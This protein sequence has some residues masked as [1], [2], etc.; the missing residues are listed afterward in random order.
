MSHSSHSNIFFLKPDTPL[1]SV[2]VGDSCLLCCWSLSAERIS[3]WDPLTLSW[4]LPN[5][6]FI[7]SCSF[8]NCANLDHMSP[9]LYAAE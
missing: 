5:L 1:L 7:S 4:A 8:P 9:L 2:T 3:D 6:E